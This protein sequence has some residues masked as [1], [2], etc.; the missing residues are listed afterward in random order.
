M[1]GGGQD[2]FLFFFKEN[3]RW[4]SSHISGDK[5][6]YFMEKTTSPDFNQVCFVPKSKQSIITE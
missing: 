3:L 5:K 6:R 2:S 4:I 1:S